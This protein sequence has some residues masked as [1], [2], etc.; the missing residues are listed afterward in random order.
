MLQ[1]IAQAQQSY[2]KD[3]SR[4]KD[5]LVNLSIPPGGK[6]FTCDATSMSQTSALDQLL[7]TFL[8]TSV[9]NMKNLPPLQQ[10]NTHR[11]NPYCVQ[12]QHHRIWRHLLETD[13]WHR[14]GDLPS[15]KM[16]HNLL[17]TVRTSPT[18]D[19]THWF[20]PLIYWWHHWHM[21]SR[22]LPSHQGQT[23][24]LLQTEYTT[25]AWVQ[26][27]FEDPSFS[28][29]FMDLTISI[30]NGHLYTTL[31]KKPQTCTYT[32]PHTHPTQ[33]ESKRDSSMDKSVVSIISAQTKMTH[34]HALKDYF[35]DWWPVVTHQR[36]WSLYS[37]KL[38]TTLLD[39]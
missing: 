16:G 28:V 12:K 3:S 32:C 35:N 22:S 27:T 4:L 15:H 13:L 34:T 38:R 2:L 19:N 20:L 10:R 33:K 6:L 18:M 26:W 23:M 5:Q 11:T 36:N 39:S 21:D 1:P 17:W 24:G 37:Y 14:H 29:N 25:V 7:N 30:V 8:A 9:Q 31:Y